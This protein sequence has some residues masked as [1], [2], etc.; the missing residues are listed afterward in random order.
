MK[1][2]LYRILAIM[3]LVVVAGCVYD[4]EPEDGDIQGLDNPL[5]VIDGDIIVG[6]IT[7][8]KIG[9]TRSLTEEEE[10]VPLGA[11]VWVEGEDGEVLSG[12]ALEEEINS[13][14]VD[15]EDLS[16]QGRYRLGVS[17]PGRG[18]YLSAFK[19]VLVSPPIDSITYSIA[20]DRS[21]ARVEVTTHNDAAYTRG[22]DTDGFLYCKWNY[23]ENWESDAIFPSE[24]EYDVKA[25]V[26]REL[27]WTETVARQYCF[28]EAESSGTFIANTEKLS[29]NVIYKSVINE[30]PN[31]DTRLMR[32]YS[33][34]VRQTALDKEAYIYWEN[35]RNNTSGTGGLFGPQPSEIRG[36]IESRT[37]P[38]EV[39]IGYINVTTMQEKR[40]FI[41]WLPERLFSTDCVLKLVPR[42]PEGSKDPGNPLWNSQ[43]N[44]GY[45]PVRYFDS[46][47]SGYDESQAYWALEKCTDCRAYSNSTKPD[48]W[49]R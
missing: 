21:Y 33:I 29:E 37:I 7:K 13:F 14:E 38:G 27:H 15:T 39:V 6:G 47:G 34:D 49:P 42:K 28:S 40:A 2:N 3:L 48:F 22:N 35:N 45:R 10:V 23:S 5:V 17:I 20:D 16:L 12:R 44:M 24:L 11:S 1:K 32:L 9:L 8:V 31:T 30:I 19:D 4:Y 41:D 46:G 36:N 26:M 43:Y 25:Q 18:E